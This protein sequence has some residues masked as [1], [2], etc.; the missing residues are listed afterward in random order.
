MIQPDQARQISEALQASKDALL[1]ALR[2]AERSAD[3]KLADQI[4]SLCGRVEAFQA[5][6]AKRMEPRQETRAAFL[7]RAAGTPTPILI[8]AMQAGQRDK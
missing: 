3:P 8:A 6:A 1:L 7:R 4:G 2:V 5:R